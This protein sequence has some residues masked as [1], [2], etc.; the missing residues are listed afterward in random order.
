MANIKSFPNNQDEYIGAEYVMRWLHGRTS[1]VFGAEGNA[2]VAPVVDTM[3]VTVSDGNGWMSN[4]NSDGIVWWISNEKDSGSKLQLSVDIADAVLPRIDRVVVQWETTNYVALPEVIIL[5]G[6]A[7]STPYAPKLTNNNVLRQISLARIKIPAGAT[8]ITAS[9]ITDE[10]LNKSVCGLVTCGIDVDTSVMQAQWESSYS[11]FLKYLADQQ[12]AWEA[13]FS[14]VQND[15]VL[16]VPSI[17]DI[18]RA[19]AVNDD[20]SGYKIKNDNFVVTATLSTE[21]VGTS[22]PYTQTISIENILSSDTPH[23]TPVYSGTVSN[24][25]LQK[26]AWAVIDEAETTDGA[27]VFRCFEEKPTKAVTVQIEVNR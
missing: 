23:I 7:E 9:M 20:A 11:D 10:R 22:A 27:I 19:I 18:G 26:E 8:S 3:A 15:I 1:G 24:K 17:D 13:F 12:A 16:P 6:K 14:N 25:I 21:W 5:K 4:D 2:A